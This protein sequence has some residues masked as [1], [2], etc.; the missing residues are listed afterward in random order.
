M[1]QK[2]QDRPDA[3]GKWHRMKGPSRV[4]RHLAG[5]GELVEVV[6]ES[7]KYDGKKKLYKHRTKRPRPVLAAGDGH[8]FVVGGNMKATPDGLVN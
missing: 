5:L 6:Y 2:W 1:F 8:V 4:P 7:N 3:R